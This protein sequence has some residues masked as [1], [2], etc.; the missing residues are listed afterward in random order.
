M[1]DAHME[2]TVTG[3]AAERCKAFAAAM[4]QSRRLRLPGEHAWRLRWAPLLYTVTWLITPWY[5]HSA[6]GWASFALFY[7]MFLVAFFQTFRDEGQQLIWLGVLF[8]LGYVYFPFNESIAGEFVYPVVISVFFLRQPKASSAFKRFA[9]ILGAQAAGLLLETR[10][11]HASPAL[12]EWVIFYAVV[13]GLSNFAQSRQVLVS[14]QLVQ[15]NQ[16]IEHLTQVAERERIARDLHDLLG[17]T[18]TV[19][20]LKSDVANRLFTAQPDLAHREIAEVEATARKA[21]AEVREAVA[22]YRAEGFPAEILHA[23]R[24]LVSAGVQLTTDIEYFFLSS[25]HTNMLCLI[26]REA[27]TNVIRHAGATV[28]HLK[29]H[30]NGDLLT[31]SIEDNGSGKLGIEGNGLRGMRERLASAGGTLQRER[32]VHGGT[33]LTVEFQTSGAA[34][35]A[36]QPPDWETSSAVFDAANSG[37]VQA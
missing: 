1:M 22:G 33:R 17:H 3:R 31:M 30:R 13:I 10:L 28:C 15:A 11:I 26:L 25:G 8:L 29:L 23:R 16:E 18:L 7:V 32:S 20:V 6:T 14:E 21:L 35:Q 24:T 36:A 4:F 37:T 9:A 2:T 12:A 19:I 5:R 34:W 27:V